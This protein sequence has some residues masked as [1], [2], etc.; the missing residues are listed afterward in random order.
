MTSLPASGKSTFG[1]ILADALNF[2]LIDTDQKIEAKEQKSIQ[3]IFAEEGEPH[4]RALERED[5]M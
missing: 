3:K 4:F 5:S 2:Q 1:K